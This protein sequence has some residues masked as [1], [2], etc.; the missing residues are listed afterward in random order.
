MRKRSLQQIAINHAYMQTIKIL[1]RI[2]LVIY[3]YGRLARKLLWVS[4]VDL[5]SKS[6]FNSFF[7][8]RVGVK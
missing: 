6:E 3:C 2:D 7:S 8:R 4:F 1:S 5:F